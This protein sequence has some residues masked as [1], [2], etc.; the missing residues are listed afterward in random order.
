MISG[1]ARNRAMAD[2]AELLHKFFAQKSQ[3]DDPLSQEEALWVQTQ[4]DACSQ[5]QPLSRDF[6][7]SHSVVGHEPLDNCFLSQPITTETSSSKKYDPEDVLKKYQH[8]YSQSASCTAKPEGI[9]NE[10]KNFPTLPILESQ[11]ILT[12]VIQM[13]IPS[14]EEKQRTNEIEIVHDPMKEPISS[15]PSAYKDQA[16]GLTIT[17]SAIMSMLGATRSLDKERTSVKP[18]IEIP[19]A[20]IMVPPPAVEETSFSFTQ[21]STASQSEVLIK[22]FIIDMPGDSGTP[23]KRVRRQ[24]AVDEPSLA[25]KAS[26]ATPVAPTMPSPPLCV[27]EFVVPEADPIA[28]DDL[29]RRARELSNSQLPT[30]SFH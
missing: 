25:F 18:S 14:K 2:P 27:F 26:A 10:A 5:S 21:D 28:D 9:S 13:F 1:A 15:S 29:R 20:S 17:A 8:F 12:P 7:D 4:L 30:F 19:A 3:S 16:G 11:R 22:P 23:A 6:E 24:S